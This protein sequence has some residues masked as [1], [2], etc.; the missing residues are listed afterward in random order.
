MSRL[1]TVLLSLFFASII[2]AQVPIAQFSVNQTSVC[3]GFPITF[4]DQSI[5]SGSTVIS[6]NWDFGEG[7]QSTNTNPTYTY[8]NPGVYTVLLTVISAGGTDFEQKLQYITVYSIPTA[9]FT[10]SGNGCSIP[11]SVSFSNNSSIGAGMS[12]NWSFG[13]GQ[14]SNLQNP[15]AI[16]YNSAGTFPVQLIVTN[17]NTSCTKTVSQSLV[18]ADFSAGITSSA[19]GCIGQVTNLTDASTVG[20][21]SWFWSSGDG[22]TSTNQNTSFTYLSSGNYT[23]S[24]TAQNSNSGCSSTTTKSISI[25]PL[26]NPTFT[27]N[28]LAGCA[29][30]AVTFSNTSGAGVF[31]WDFGNGTVSNVKNP[32]IK[33]YPINGSYSVALT[34]TDVNGCIANTTVNNMITVGPPI[35]LFS[36]AVVNG[37]APLPVEFIDAST[38]VDPLSDPIVSW[39]W[40]FGD[41]VTFIGKNPPPHIY[42]IGTFTVSLKV[43]TQHGCTVTSTIPAYIQVG[44]IDMVDF[45]LFPLNE[46]SKKDID[47]TN[48]SVITTPHNSN[49]VTYDWDFGDH[50]TSTEENPKYNYPVDTG[51]FDIQ[52]IVTFRGC[53]DTLIKINQIYIKAPISKFTV[54]SLYCNPLVFPIVANVTDNSIAGASTDNVDLTWRWGDGT[55][56]NFLNSADV[57]DLDKGSITHNF[58]TYGTYIIK[59]VIN[60][61]TTGCSDSL[62]QTIYITSMDASFILSNDT[63]CSTS[64][65]T[66]TST[67]IFRDPIATFFYNLGNGD[68]I[69][70]DSPVYNYLTPGTYNIKLSAT[71][72]VGCIDSSKFLNFIV[73]DPPLANFTA[74]ATSGCLPITANFINNSS[75]QGNGVPFNSFLWTYPD[76]TLQTTNS[77]ATATQFEFS[78]EGLFSTTLVATDV[79]GCVSEPALQPMFITNPSVN[80]TMNPVVCN[81]ENFNAVN[82]SSG[83]GVLSYKWKLDNIDAGN[84][85]DYSN[86]FNEITSSAYTNIPHDIRLIVQDGNGCKDSLN[87]IVRVSLPHA[88]LSFVASGATA[89]GFGEYTCPPVFETFTDHSTSFGTKTNWNWSFGDGKSS[90]FQSPNNTYVFPGT[91]SASLTVTNEY[92]CSDDTTLVDYLKILGPNGTLNWASLGDL[93]LHNYE[94]TLSNFTFV[95]S[96]VWHMDD[97]D[98]VYN[99]IDF[100]HIY[101]VGSFMPT[102]SLIDSLG[103]KVT[104]P[105]NNLIVA[106]IV[107]SADAGPDQAFC[108]NSTALSGNSDPNGTGL[109]TLYSGSGTITTP[110]SSTSNVSNIGIGIN[111]FVWSNTND[112]TTISDTM[113]ITIIDAS[114]IA[115]AGPDQFTCINS[116]T[117]SGNTAMIGVGTWTLVSGTGIITAPLNPLSGVTGLGIGVNKFVWTI[118]N[119]CSSSNDT[120]SIIVETTPTIPFAGPD[121]SACIPNTVLEGNTALVG[122]GVWTLHSG[123]GLIT[124][125]NSPTSG[126][127]GLPLGPNVFVWTISNTCGSASDQ[128][129]ITGVDAPTTSNAGP[130][131]FTCFTNSILHSNKSSIG[132]GKWIL[133]SGQGNITNVTDSLTPVTGLGIGANV[134]EWSIVSLCGTS[135]DR[136]TITVETPPTIANAG[137]DDEI[138]GSEINLHGN[139]P[140]VGIGI[141]TLSSG[142]GTIT[143]QNLETTTISDLGV[144]FNV[145]KWT[146][147]NS[148]SSS[149]DEVS[150]EGVI[151]P[152]LPDAGVDSIFCGSGFTLQGN[153]NTIGIGIWTT[154]GIASITTPNSPVSTVSNLSIGNNTFTWT[155]S[156]LCG[157]NSQDVILIREDNPTFADAGV[158]KIICGSST[159]L[160]ALPAYIGVGLWSVESPITNSISIT[161]LNLENSLVSNLSVGINILKWTITNTCGSNISIVELKREE[162]PTDPL[163]SPIPPIC[164]TNSKLTGNS[165]ITGTGVWTLISG[166]GSITNPIDPVSAVTNLGLGS[167]IF[168]W[169]IFNDCNSSYK[170]VTIIVE[171]APTPATVGPD[172]NSCGTEAILDGKKPQPGTGIWTLV[173]G[174]ASINSP[175][176]STSGVN[177]VTIGEHVFMWTI[178]NS[179]GTSSAELKIT[180]NGLCPDVDSVK[181]QLVYFIPNTF[182]PNGD[183]N[184]QTFQPIFTS[185]YEPLKYTLYIFDRWGEKLFVSHDANIG[186]KGT[187][188]VDGNLVQDGLYTWKIIFTDIITQKEHIKSGHVILIR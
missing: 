23:I 60:N 40:N 52:L 123:A 81:L 183:L 140:L 94:F 122:I 88:D 95:D 12:Y 26:P 116:V 87:Q 92:G 155:I 178:S 43:T 113:S 68:T 50:G 106:P 188:G 98:T 139:D 117:L 152:T 130:D 156:N 185:G 97:G 134:F 27:A 31:H 84:T 119:T 149:F 83:F 167:N 175:S 25:N 90:N 3:A 172:Q 176:D 80:F 48:L 17:S 124:S 173:S 6:T 171:S 46:C 170:E 37:C 59:Q 104:Y 96:I 13:N 121:Q 18:I 147:S 57:L 70:G 30:L 76:G 109:W 150:I 174:S 180:N 166:S 164:I 184:N 89:N 126:L 102:G 24:L 100:T 161:D 182:T 58:A 36:S 51:F 5:Y 41:G 64:P 145:F 20:V 9:T 15:P 105:M 66:L 38:S 14:T 7:G 62:Q 35:A 162:P 181:N 56:D 22:Q 141:W 11:F 82:T 54:P 107:I 128:I 148:C 138:C 65:L 71:N 63:V 32:P 115:A 8:M 110:N 28:P 33:T 137:F 112:C 168:R 86:S 163:V 99:S 120:V 108:G 186:W 129:T 29:P 135:S 118:S 39:L 67:S 42:G 133:I 146:I 136:I 34:M 177:N 151:P 16:T 47:F 55:P 101:P 158:N 165:V 44:M 160:E 79:F 111:K 73:L 2:F 4:N 45:S 114:T 125:I 85:I 19:S 154:N 131:Q 127:T 93:C 179:C 103:C 61:H 53:K 187:Y 142:T 10:S 69:S 74:S 144:G 91:Y 72:S 49:E 157:T 75:T 153:T 1:I 169:T 132:L 159:N 78:S 77:L 21:N 143:S